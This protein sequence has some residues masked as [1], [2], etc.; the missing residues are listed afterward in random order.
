MCVEPIDDEPT[1]KCVKAPVLRARGPLTGRAEVTLASADGKLDEPDTVSL[2]PRPLAAR[3]LGP[4]ISVAIGSEAMPMVRIGGAEALL[5]VG[6]GGAYEVWLDAQ[7]H[8]D[9]AE[10]AK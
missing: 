10:L 4:S 3:A 2:A 8:I 5:V 6:P 1:Y 7:G 9:S